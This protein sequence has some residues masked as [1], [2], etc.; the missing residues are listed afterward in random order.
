MVPLYSTPMLARLFPDSVQVVVAA[1]DAP[2]E[3]LFPEEEAA[4]A[5]AVAKRRRDFTLGRQ[6][7]REALKRLG[8]AVGPIPTG[9][10]RAP[11]WPSGIVG[12][13]THCEL[14]AA[15]AV[16]WHRD[17]AG[18]GLDAELAAPLEPKLVRLICTAAEQERFPAPDACTGT[19]WP[20]LAFSAKEA[21]HKAIAPASGN[22]LGFREVEIEFDAV[23]ETFTARLITDRLSGLPD[24]ARLAGRF[25]V[26]DGLVATSA[27][28]IHSP[29]SA[30]E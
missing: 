20:K 17:F 8:A 21:V 19:D 5:R 13:I 14:I 11:V 30:P 15:A 9:P 18:L 3:P 2:L 16:G 24:F 27:V 28:L 25:L 12:S 23:A 1:A 26:G 10:R 22:T 29:G 6:C 4:L 7:A